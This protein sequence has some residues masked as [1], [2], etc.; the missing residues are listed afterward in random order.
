MSVDASVLTLPGVGGKTADKLGAL[1][2]ETVGDL[3]TRLPR[4]YEDRSRI[5][6]VSELAP[7]DVAVVRGEVVAVRQGRRRGRRRAGAGAGGAGIDPL[8]F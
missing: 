8:Q 7:G 1:G 3:L 6:P 2:I 4:G 5:T